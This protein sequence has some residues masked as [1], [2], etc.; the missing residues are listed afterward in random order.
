[1]VSENWPQYIYIFSRSHAAQEHDLGVVVQIFGKGASIALQWLAIV[2]LADVHRRAAENLHPLF[3]D[4]PRWRDEPV[5]RGDDERVLDTPEVHR[6]GDLP[7]KIEGAH[8]G[9][10][11]R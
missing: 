11:N 3:R 9:E 10:R 2:A 7:A 6:V 8:V 4:A 1:M 5:S